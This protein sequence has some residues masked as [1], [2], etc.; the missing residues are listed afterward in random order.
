MSKRGRTLALLVAAVAVSSAERTC[1]PRAEQQC[2]QEY[3]EC[4][5]V[6][7][8]ERWVRGHRSATA[9]AATTSWPLSREQDYMAT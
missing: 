6:G 1:N 2:I 8:A 4:R 3:E 5:Q 7:L 9:A